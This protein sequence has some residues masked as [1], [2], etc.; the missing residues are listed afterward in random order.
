MN[1][2]TALVQ[3]NRIIKCRLLN[4]GSLSSKAVLINS[5]I[6][7]YHTDLFCLPNETMR[8]SFIKMMPIDHNFKNVAKDV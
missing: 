7:D 5:Q 2:S 1:T 3:P 8:Y 4:I 6:S